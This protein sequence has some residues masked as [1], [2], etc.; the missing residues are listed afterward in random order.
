MSSNETEL[1]KRHE[2]ML[3]MEEKVAGLAQDSLLKFAQFTRPEYQAN[4]HHKRLCSLLDRFVRGEAPRVM[5]F[6][7]P[8]HGKSELVSRCLPAYILGRNPNAAVIAT[9]YAADL[10]SRMNR[11]VQRIIDSR[12]YHQVFPDTQLNATNVQTVAKDSSGRGTWLRNNSIFEIVGHRGSYRSA[13][14]GGGITGMGGDFLIIDDPI[15]SQED[16]YSA[17]YR[18][19]VWDWYIS[20]FYSRRRGDHAGVLLTLTR[21]HEDDLAGRLLKLAARDPAADQWEVLSFPAI[22]D[23]PP[24]DH[25]HRDVGEALWPNRFSTETLMKNKANGEYFWNAL[26]QQ[27]PSALAG[28]LIKREWIQF[29]DVL[30]AELSD[31]QQ[32]W[33]LT[34][35]G[36]NDRA[37]KKGSWVVGQVWAR[38]GADCYLLDQYRGRPDFPETLRAIASMTA[39]HPNALR[40]LI[41]DAANGPAV[42]ASL[43]DKIPGI[44]AVSTKGQSKEAR[45]HTVTPMFEAGN[46]WLPRWAEPLVEELVSFP[47]G[48]NDD[49]VDALSMALN[50]YRVAAFTDINMDLSFGLKTENWRY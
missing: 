49:Q 6:M 32:S 47:N 19:K 17:V 41:E 40:K 12:E 30:P 1:R 16:A 29:Y 25:D 8:Q 2:L 42:I 27:R 13:G 28:N 46:I 37:S 31:Y 26:Y 38:K 23:G 44:V 39:K 18:D 21:W 24:D 15:K 14:V 20:T 45:L 43:R 5:V 3:L 4:W 36:G 11:D 33:D 35:K 48:V 9:S 10:S 7:P 34:F 22:K 50:N